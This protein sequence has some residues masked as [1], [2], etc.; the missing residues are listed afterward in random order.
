L[1]DNISFVGFLFFF[2]FSGIDEEFV[3]EEFFYIIWDE[4]DIDQEE[5]KPDENTGNDK[6]SDFYA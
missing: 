2:V 6:D 5:K 3:V 4:V 1:K